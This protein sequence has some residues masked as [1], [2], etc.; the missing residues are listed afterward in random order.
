MKAKEK[1]I[2]DLEGVFLSQR[3]VY[4]INDTDLVRVCSNNGEYSFSIISREGL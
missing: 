1:K 4:G 2:S 3:S